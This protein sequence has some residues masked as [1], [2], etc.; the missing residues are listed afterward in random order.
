MLEAFTFVLWVTFFYCFF[1]FDVTKLPAS[2]I[3]TATDQSDHSNVPADCGLDT[4][5]GLESVTTPTNQSPAAT[6]TSS[7]PVTTVLDTS[8]NNLPE[9][10]PTYDEPNPTPNKSPG[11]TPTYDVIQTNQLL[12]APP[13]FCP[14]HTTTPTLQPSPMEQPLS[15]A[16]SAVSPN[17]AATSPAAIVVETMRPIHGKRFRE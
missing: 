1:S 2:D 16:T 12:E 15:I 10:T 9:T 8:T 13:A 14:T 3:V 7:P 4:S 17:P 5:T 6:P 11:A